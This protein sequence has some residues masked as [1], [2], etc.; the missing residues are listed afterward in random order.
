[1]R[2]RTEQAPTSVSPVCMAESWHMEQP[3]PTYAGTGSTGLDQGQRGWSLALPS[4]MSL[5]HAQPWAPQSGMGGGVK[6]RKRSPRLP[7]DWL[8]T[9]DPPCRVKGSPRAVRGAMTVHPGFWGRCSPGAWVS[10]RV[11]LED[12]GPRLQQSPAL[13]QQATY[14]H[15]SLQVLVWEGT[16]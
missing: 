1:M 6:R 3:V 16:W 9:P 14:R 11:K 13:A 10:S 2:L 5:L 8:G 4:F 15:P 7:S 12:P